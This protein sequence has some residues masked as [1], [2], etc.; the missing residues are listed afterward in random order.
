MDLGVEVEMNDE[1]LAATETKNINGP[2]HLESGYLANK[3]SNWPKE[4]V[5]LITGSCHGNL[6]YRKLDQARPRT[7]LCSA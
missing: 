6:L 1:D 7:I 5:F 4:N 2:Y 3:Y